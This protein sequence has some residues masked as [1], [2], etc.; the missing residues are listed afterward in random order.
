MDEFLLHFFSILYARK[1]YSPKTAHI[2]TF[3]II[4]LQSNLS[5]VAHF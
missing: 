5:N 1:N 2:F 3:R 4:N